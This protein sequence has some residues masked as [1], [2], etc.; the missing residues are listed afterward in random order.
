MF[1]GLDLTNVTTFG[2]AGMTWD[3]IARVRETARSMK[4]VLKGIVTSEDATLAD[5]AGSATVPPRIKRS[6]VPSS[7]K[8]IG[9]EPSGF[10]AAAI[11]F[12]PG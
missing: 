7:A 9:W 8:R 4:I 1:N 2:D 11:L 10:V 3:Y 12:S 6:V 5:F